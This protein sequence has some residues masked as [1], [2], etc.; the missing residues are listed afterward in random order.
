MSDPLFHTPASDEYAPYYQ[1]YI[2]LLSDGDIL[3]ILEEQMNETLTLLASLTDEQAA[4]SY[5]PGKWSLKEV[6][7]H[8]IDCERV[9]AYRG[10]CFAR[11][12]NTPLPS[13][14]QDE[15]VLGAD[16]NDKPL[17][18]LASEFKHLRM[19]NI[20]MFSTWSEAVQ[21]RRGTAANNS[22]TARAIPFI[23]AGHERHHLNIIAKRYL[24][25]DERC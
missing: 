21:A 20:F 11:G 10:M 6:I 8:I 4:I 3:R 1:T 12:D 2:S 7:G 15:Y 25:S 24:S 17:D 14:E 13:F 22:I 9:F 23:L 18:K 19:S 5:A 16:F